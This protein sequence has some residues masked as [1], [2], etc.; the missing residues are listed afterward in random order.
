MA[1]SEV[2]SEFIYALPEPK[3]IDQRNPFLCFR[4][5]QREAIQEIVD[6]VE[7][8]QKV[9]QLD[10]GVGAG[11]SL[12]LAI[13]ARCLRDQLGLKK[14]LYT[15]PQ[16]KLIDQIRDDKLLRIPTLAGKANYPCALLE[17]EK[18]HCRYTSDR[19]LAA[20]QRQKAVAVL[21][22]DRQFGLFV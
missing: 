5:G 13:A 3:T 12:I 1:S 20:W 17:E 6:K 2:V 9:I 4:P 16:V 8:G 19:L 7:S 14:A 11:K 22:L 21:E 18:G 10:A 15:T